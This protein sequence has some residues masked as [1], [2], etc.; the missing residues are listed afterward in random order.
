MKTLVFV[1][2]KVFKFIFLFWVVIS[3]LFG[4]YMIADKFF[5]RTVVS[6]ALIRDFSSASLD[7]EDFS[8][9][10]RLRATTIGR[11]LWR[12]EHEP[13]PDFSDDNS[14]G[15]PYELSINFEHVSA[16]GIMLR[17]IKLEQVQSGRVVFEKDELEVPIEMG[18]S[19]YKSG[20]LEVSGLDSAHVKHRLSAEICAS[21]ALAQTLCIISFHTGM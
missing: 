12:D 7:L 8:I 20:R 2:R 6:W 15:T 14:T 1:L 18:Y 16:P 11:R 10:A 9:S 4:T 19:G 5:G 3:S 21:G 17:H 13:K